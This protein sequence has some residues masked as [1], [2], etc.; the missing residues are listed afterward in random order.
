MTKPWYHEGLRFSCTQCGKCCTG[1]PGVVWIT[2]EE[3]QSMA[4]FLNITLENFLKTYT[5]I[6][7]GKRS[8][9]EDAKTYDCIFL[10]DRQCKVYGNR[11]K[12]C[13][14]FPFW[15]ENVKSKQ[16]WDQLKSYCEGINHE[17]APV[18]AFS[19]IQKT[20]DS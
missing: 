14:T 8:L 4:D 2:K 5:R 10:K 13:R 12:Q 1:A 11:P 18:I 9:K 16:S 7:D 3:A 20:L 17:D 19:D 6:V 15:K